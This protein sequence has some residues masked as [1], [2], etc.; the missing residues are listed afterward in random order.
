MR[1]IILSRSTSLIWNGRF[2]SLVNQVRKSCFSK[3]KCSHTISGKVNR[4]VSSGCNWFCVRIV[5]WSANIMLLKQLE[6]MAINSKRDKAN[7]HILAWNWCKCP[8]TQRPTNLL[9][10]IISYPHQSTNRWTLHVITN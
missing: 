6:S 8:F 5:K 2:F 3:L 7:A 9:W 4:T 1:K 10:K